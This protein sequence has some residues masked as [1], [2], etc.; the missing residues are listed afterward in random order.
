MTGTTHSHR[1]AGVAEY[2]EFGHPVVRGSANWVVFGGVMLILLGSIHAIQGL[3]ALLDGG[4]YRVRPSGLVVHVSYTT[5]GWGHL[6]LG[7]LAALTGIGLLAGNMAARV[8]GVVLAVVSALVNLAFIAAFP[9]WSAIVITIDVVVIY[10]I[11][12]HGAELKKRAR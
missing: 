2:D 5:W 8:V 3:V 6:V 9:L 7:I 10:A 1:A 11:I 12:V 4:Y